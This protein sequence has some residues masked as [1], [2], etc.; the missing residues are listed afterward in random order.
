MWVWVRTKNATHHIEFSVLMNG[1]LVE[2]SKRGAPWKCVLAYGIKDAAQANP[3]LFPHKVV[4]AYV[5][6]S[7]VYIII[8][9]PAKKRPTSYLPAIV[10]RHNFTK[11][12][13]QFDNITKAQFLEL[14]GNDGALIR[15]KPPMR[16]HAG[17]EQATSNPQPARAPTEREASKRNPLVGALRRAKDAGLLTLSTSDSAPP[18]A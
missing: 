14:F 16:R 3:R 5:E 15:L 7:K 2:R 13:R 1:D 9:G 6:G 10:Y 17:A 12:L 11:Q 8:N 4:D 18:A